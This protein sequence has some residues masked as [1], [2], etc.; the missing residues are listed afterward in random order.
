MGFQ[1]FYGP[2]AKDMHTNGAIFDTRKAAEA[3]VTEARSSGRI[4]PKSFTEIRKS[5]PAYEVVARF[6][7]SDGGYGKASQVAVFRSRDEA[8]ASV[9]GFRAKRLGHYEVK[10][11]PKLPKSLK[12]SAAA[13][14]PSPALATLKLSSKGGRP[15]LDG[16]IGTGAS[17]KITV[18]L[19]LPLF[20]M[21]Q[22]ALTPK[23]PRPSDV[24]RDA[25]RFY[26]DAK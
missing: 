10:A 3:A 9:E 7:E 23:L 2:N 24:I 16:E 5:A 17:P 20:V 6:R 13:R 8:Y 26:L 18:R 21:L 12:P 11:L 15:T 4:P 19:P 14:K 25:L 22:A 1:F